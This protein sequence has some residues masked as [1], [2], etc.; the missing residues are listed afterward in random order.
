RQPAVFGRELS[1]VGKCTLGLRDNNARVVQPKESAV[2]GGMPKVRRCSQ[3]VEILGRILPQHDVHALAIGN[4]LPPFHDEIVG[5]D[6]V[7]VPA[8]AGRLATKKVRESKLFSVDGIGEDRE[9]RSPA[10]DAVTPAMAD[11]CGIERLAKSS[12]RAAVRIAP[13]GPQGFTRPDLA[14]A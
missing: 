14:L 3:L 9:P 5:T 7:P 2:E 6:D 13:S 4:R 11:P 12:A 1:E 10:S 8:Q